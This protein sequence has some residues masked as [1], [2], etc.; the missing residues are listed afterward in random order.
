MLLLRCYMKKI[1]TSFFIAFFIFLFTTGPVLASLV[2][3]DPYYK[4]QW[5]LSKIKA[6][7]AWSKISESPDIVIAVIDSGVDI[8]HPDLINNIWTNEK[9]VVGNGRD[10]DHNGYIDDIHGWDFVNN[11]SDPSPK[12][13]G[14]W[15][16]AGVSHG[17]TVA[18]IIAAQGNNNQGVAGVTW[19]AKIMPL[20]VLDDKGDGKISDVIKAI[21]YAT[22][23][24]AD[25]IN[26]SFVNFIYNQGMQD[27]IRR[28]HNAGILIV[29]AAGNEQTN[30]KAYNIDKTPIYPACYDGQLVGENMIIGVVATDALDQKASFSSYGHRCVDI[31][32]PGISFFNAV[33]PGTSYDNYN[34]YYDGYWSGTSMAAPLV[35]GALALIEQANP[36]LSPREVVNILFA[37][38]DNISLLNPD[39]L[40]QLGN[41]RLNIDRAIEMAKAELYSH[42]GRLLIVPVSGQKNFK[43]SASNGD[44]VSEFKGTENLKAGSIASGDINGDGVDEIVVGSAPGQ[45]PQIQILN[46]KGKV[47]KKFLAYNKSFRGGV[48]IA[49][50]DIN[51]DGNAEIITAPASAGTPEIKFFDENGKLLKQ[52]MAFDKKSKMGLNLALGYLNDPSQL[53]LVVGSGAGSEPLVKIFSAAGNLITSFYPY[54]K[55]FRGGVKVAVA[56]LDGRKD[57]GQSEIIIAPGAGR[58]PLVK[59]YNGDLGLKKQFLAYN[60]NWQ[61][62]LNISAGDV[63]NDG[64]SEII[65]GANPGAAP[66]VRIFDG[67]ANLVESFYAWPESFKG[68]VIPAIIRMNN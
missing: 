2:P 46:T 47:L 60:K 1:V 39:Y 54:E 51:N 62:G 42:V 58:D 66:H 41:G 12:F 30:G 65:L 61:G 19:K 8:N 5:Y 33:M 23:N 37:S 52:F 28:A 29:A 11:V 35:S 13:K 68:G 38:T 3:N 36:E 26:L 4:N 67:E 16:E 32:A 50:A 64:I 14:V 56:N 43:I 49:V 55:K 57:H 48:N 20:K 21:D 17:T 18:G 59:I 45:D 7:S 9:E 27:A 34:K 15:T 31:A 6:D 25:I 44:L 10:D 24:G 53:E 40:G 22:A 63:N